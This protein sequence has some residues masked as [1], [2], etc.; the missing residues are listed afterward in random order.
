ME[1]DKQI[2][3]GGEISPMLCKLNALTRYDGSAMFT[4]GNVSFINQLQMLPETN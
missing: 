1:I 2:E 3:Y 4:Q